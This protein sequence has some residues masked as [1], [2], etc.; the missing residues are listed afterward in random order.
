MPVMDRPV[1]GNWSVYLRGR[2]LGASQLGQARRPAAKKRAFYAPY[3]GVG[4]KDYHG[5]TAMR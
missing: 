2:Q 3:M 1:S 4:G 5:Q